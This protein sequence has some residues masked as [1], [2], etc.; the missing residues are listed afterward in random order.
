MVK[1][2]A[3]QNTLA[4][5]LKVNNRR[6][7]SILVTGLSDGAEGSL[8]DQARY[9]G[10]DIHVLPQLVREVSPISD[11]IALAALVRII[12]REKPA[13]VHTHTSKAGILG[14]IAA[15]MAG[16]PVIIHTPH[17]HIFHDY[18][19]RPKTA[20]FIRLER[21]CARYTDRLIMLTQNE[22][23]DHLALK[24]APPER[25]TVIFSGVDLGQFTTN[26][27][28]RGTLRN[29]F[30]LSNGVRVI[31]TVGR[32]VPIKGQIHLIQAMPKI[33]QHCPEAHLVLVGDG[34]LRDELEKAATDLRVND[35]V[36][37]AGYREDV[38]NCLA[39][40]DL[41]VL[42]SLNEGMGRVIVEAM[43]M[44]LPVVASDVC[45]I[46]DLV[47][48]KVS[49]LLV[50]PSD[51]QALAEAII[52]LLSNRALV[53]RYA[54]AGYETVVPAFGEEIMIEKIERLYGALLE[55]KGALRANSSESGSQE[56][57]KT[58]DADERGQDCWNK[59]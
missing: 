18:F 1:G 37:F 32:L 26:R 59:N 53:E 57:V 34:P 40:F 17:G 38:A 5:V 41:F 42:P 8:L 29:R 16:A 24:I 39:D 25:F 49:G 19:S 56:L 31:G 7:R 9:E 23:D 6:Y 50:P 10:V 52:H 47:K 36:H 21:L 45:G 54:E 13:I 58:A 4:T 22:M 43:A 55:E 44:R 28:P 27:P 14:R 48:D 51:H 15:R 3:Q 11:L 35:A 30:G 20:L 46:R 12:R 2:G 33:R